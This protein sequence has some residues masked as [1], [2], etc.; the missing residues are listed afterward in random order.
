MCIL[1]GHDLVIWKS[2]GENIELIQSSL[3]LTWRPLIVF[4][5]SNIRGLAPVGAQRL[6]L[7]RIRLV[8]SLDGASVDIYC[9]L[10]G[11]GIV[12]SRQMNPF[13]FRDSLDSCSPVHCL[14]LVSLEEAHSAF[15]HDFKVILS[16]FSGVCYSRSLC[17]EYLIDIRPCDVLDLNPRCYSNTQCWLTLIE[18]S[19]CLSKK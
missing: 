16:L 12:I 3:E 13:I 5:G 14:V 11:V 9:S 1:K 17:H 2:T 4:K 19:P 10:F 6:S 7:L 15:V 8:V 18:N